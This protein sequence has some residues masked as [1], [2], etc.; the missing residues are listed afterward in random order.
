MV[1]RLTQDNIPE[2]FDGVVQELH[3]DGVFEDYDEPKGTAVAGDRNPRYKITH[4]RNHAK[5]TP[6]LR[7]HIGDQP[8]DVAISSAVADVNSRNPLQPRQRELLDK[9]RSLQE[10]IKFYIPKDKFAHYVRY[11]SE[12]LHLPENRELL[13]QSFANMAEQLG[14]VDG[15]PAE[16][17]LDND[18]LERFIGAVTTQ[19]RLEKMDDML[20]NWAPHLL[21]FEDGT[22]NYAA[23]LRAATVLGMSKALYNAPE[24]PEL[25]LSLAI[26]QAAHSGYRQEMQ[27]AVDKAA[28]GQGNLPPLISRDEHE[29]AT[30]VVQE[31]LRQFDIFLI[32]ST[33]LPLIIMEHEKLSKTPG[34]AMDEDAKTRQAIT[35]GW[36]DFFKGQLLRSDTLSNAAYTSK[37]YESER[38]TMVC[39]AKPH[40]RAMQAEGMLEA[41]FDGVKAHRDVLQDLI[42]TAGDYAEKVLSGQ[43]VP[44]LKEIRKS[45][46]DASDKRIEARLKELG[47]DTDGRPYPE[48]GNDVRLI[49]QE[50]AAALLKPLETLL[51]KVAERMEV[52]PKLLDLGEKLDALKDYAVADEISQQGKDVTL[53]HGEI[54]SQHTINHFKLKNI[55]TAIVEGFKAVPEET[56][57]RKAMDNTLPKR[58]LHPESPSHADKLAAQGKQTDSACPRR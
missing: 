8:N 32:F 21:K 23:G 29:N 12:N 45:I 58:A 27:K 24:F 39:P 57:L 28:I 5:N 7:Y 50:E 3:N 47:L 42:D 38:L 41:I 13:Q 37:D 2:F 52:D 36:A 6:G 53:R 46:A 15:Y 25:L 56:E 48:L 10:A 44:E 1:G 34:L 33:L 19:S 43:E 55:C 54:S 35:N 18:Q 4:N 14:F 40:L 30:A 11:F 26:F 22:P 49:S 20:A 17:K 9:T 51:N 31:S 16:T